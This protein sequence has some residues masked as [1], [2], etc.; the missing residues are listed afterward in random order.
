VAYRSRTGILSALIL[1]LGL[2]S[3]GCW[4]NGNGNTTA[5][6]NR[7][8]QKAD[9]NQ[10]NPQPRDKVQQGGRLVWPTST[11]A[12]FNYGQLDGTNFDGAMMINAVMPMLFSFD[13]TGTPIHDSDY[14]VAEPELVTSPK[15]VVTYRLNPKAIWY[16]GTSITAADFIAQWKALN[17]SNTAFQSS[18]NTGYNQIESVTQG[19]DKFEVVVTFKTP[20][21]DWKSLFYPLYPASTNTDPKVFNT[22]WKQKFLTSGGPFKFQ[23]YDA[24]AKTFTYVPNE[25]WWGNKPKLDSMIFRVIDD[26]ATPT[27]LANGEIDLMDIGPSA[28]YYNKA[29]V[30]PGVDIRVAGGP[31]F[32]HLTMNGEAAVLKDVRVRQALA[33]AI[34]RSA[35]ARAQLGPLPVNP[36]PLGNH[37]F[38]QNQK[39]YQ[40]NSGVVAYNLDKAKQLLDEAGW[41][42]KDGKRM[43]DGKPL[44][45]NML[46]PAAVPT[47]K[48]ESLVIQNL[49]SQ[50]NV[51]LEINAVPLDDFFDK[52]ITPGS[53]DFTVFS[54]MGTQFPISS[55]QSIYQK[56]TGTTVRQ[57]YARIGSD[58]IDRLY[59]EVTQELDPAK[60]IEKANEI[61]KLIWQ[62][63]HSLTMYQRPDI[64][65]TKSNLANMGAYGFASITY[66]D[67][68]WMAESAAKAP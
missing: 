11:P 16:D 13:A 33:M 54:W 67:I 37:L 28:D 7:I 53:F 36:V 59:R 57:N 66:E 47:S 21:S 64:W 62:E 40:D 4:G 23:S 34:D 2:L 60:A 50:V 5:P 17:G 3:S 18:S 41:V 63:V 32:R 49:L 68:G 15:Q 48:S 56:P 1:A 14:L 51:Q 24:T 45:V 42:V 25:K 35:I 58:D 9:E 6:E 39:G 30:V 52:Y 26:D 10:I 43:K 44:V 29:K 55:A 38:M 46:I 12:N 20:F 8:S 27:A 19:A 31:N 61:D 65:A 22:G